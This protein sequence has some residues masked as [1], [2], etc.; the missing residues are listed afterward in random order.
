M[1]S[2][3]LKAVWTYINLCLFA[4]ATE[5]G[6]KLAFMTDAHIQEVGGPC[7]CPGRRHG[8]CNILSIYRVAESLS[9]PSRWRA[10][11]LLGEK[12]EREGV[13]NATWTLQIQVNGESSCMDQDPG[14]MWVE[15][16]IHLALIMDF[17]ILLNTD[18]LGHPLGIQ[19]FLR[20]HCY[21]W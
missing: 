17:R 21:C 7:F 12:K 6:L 16:H 11:R 13:G 4:V 8:W 18:I 9:L 20:F 2:G 19:S 15:S 1:R 14:I 10:K 5:A 3:C